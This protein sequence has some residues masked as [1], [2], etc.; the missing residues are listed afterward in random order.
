MPLSPSVSRSGSFQ[1][2]T[3]PLPR[4]TEEQTVTKADLGMEMGEYGVA[5]KMIQGVLCLL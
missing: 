2:H 4:V 5:D 1:G 3:S